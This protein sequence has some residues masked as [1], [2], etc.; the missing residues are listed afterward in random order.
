MALPTATFEDKVDASFDKLRTGRKCA[1]LGVGFVF[2]IHR[3][4]TF[5]YLLVIKELKANFAIE[6]NW[7]RIGFEM[8]LIFTPPGG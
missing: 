4:P 2:L 8:G 1:S 7:V 5:S 6:E 3:R